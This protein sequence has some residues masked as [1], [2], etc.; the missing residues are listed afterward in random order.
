M[1]RGSGSQVRDGRSGKTVL[2]AGAGVFYDPGQSQFENTNA[3]GILNYLSYNVPFGTFP[4]NSAAP[5]SSAVTSVVAA[6]GYTLPRTYQWNITLEQLS[7]QQ[8]LSVAYLGAI[9]RRLTGSVG[10]GF[11]NPG[12][13]GFNEGQIQIV[14]NAFSSS[15]N[16]LQLQFNRRLSKRI[17]ALVSYTWSHSIDNLSAASFDGTISNLA[18]FEYPDLNR[19]SSDFDV[20]QSLHGAV[21]ASLPAPRNGLGALVLRNWAASSIFFA[22][23]A[24]PTGVLIRRDQS[25]IRPDLMTGQPVY[26]YSA[27]YPGGEAL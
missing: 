24:M 6:A 9:G 21:F 10:V 23:S 7:G 13:Y 14:S 16:S 20:R 3:A 18:F 27:S 5:Q 4:N 12:D 1:L 2:R 22:R 19:G 25:Y 15:Y 17:Q 26:L 11:T 8:T